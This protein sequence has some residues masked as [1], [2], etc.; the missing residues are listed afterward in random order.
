[1]SSE[2]EVAPTLRFFF[3]FCDPF[4]DAG[5]IGVGLLRIRPRAWSEGDE[6]STV[7]FDETG[8]GEFKMLS[9]ASRRS[10]SLILVR[11]G[12]PAGVV[13]FEGGLEP[14]GGDR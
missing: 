14:D 11:T 13:V 6:S 8:S 10:L 2:P 9:G 7:D 12:D 5:G 1:V 4:V 3:F